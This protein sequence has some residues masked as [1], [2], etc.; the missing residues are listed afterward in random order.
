MTKSRII[1]IVVAVVLVVGVVL[2]ALTGGWMPP[3]GPWRYTASETSEKYHT[4]DCIWASEIKRGKRVYFASPGSAE[5]AG[6][7][8][9]Q[10]CRPDAQD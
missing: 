8:P 5:K 6:H 4:R 9:C 1:A 10:L 3:F 2:W 7:V